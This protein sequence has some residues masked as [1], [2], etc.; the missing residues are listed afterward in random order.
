MQHLSRR[1]VLQG[2]CGC[3]AMALGGCVT[4]EESRQPLKTAGYRPASNT[5][6]GGLWQKMEEF[7][8]ELKH[9][10]IRVR[11]PGL[12]RYV[13][14]LACDLAGD[15]CRNLR[16]YIVDTPHF[17]ASMAPNGMMQI[18][19]G[20][21]LRCRNEAELAAVVGH[22]IAH[23]T[24]RHTLQRYEQ[25]SNSAA[26][27]AFF[28]VLLAGVGGGGFAGLIQL[29]ALANVLAFSR[30]QEREADQIGMEM[31]SR[32]GYAPVAAAQ[33]WQGIVTE[34]DAGLSDEEKD[35]RRNK[36]SVWTATHPS[37]DERMRELNR[38]A[39]LQ[40]SGPV[41]FAEESFRTATAD[42][43]DAMMEAELS[44]HQYDR[45]LVIIDRLLEAAPGDASVHYYRGEVFRRRN[46]GNDSLRALNAYGE[47]VEIDP[48]H[49]RS[50]RG[51]GIL[52][53][54]AGRTED[55]RAAF[56]RY[57]QLDPAADDRLMIQSFLGADT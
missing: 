31:M 5:L 42:R 15:H 2:L 50:W 8:E 23:Y 20:L 35:E 6:E 57:L 26:A 48:S 46:D 28:S 39:A 19:T 11:D 14:E 24:Q 53:R 41:R 54:R 9:S 40:I 12:N 34:L 36:Q 25:L 30:D 56:R 21:L 13:N 27:A 1:T 10:P 17:N 32:A 4:S 16:V 37:P 44:L 52:H 33:I 47:A 51:I 22:E 49:A 38:M 43:R 18:W 7:E 55:A 3:S 29:A 45:S